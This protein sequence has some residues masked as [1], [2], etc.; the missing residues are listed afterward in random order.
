MGLLPFIDT[1]SDDLDQGVPD[2][3]AYKEAAMKFHRAVYMG[4][5]TTASH[6][7]SFGKFIDG[8]ASSMKKPPLVFP[9]FA[10]PTTRA[11]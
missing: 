6:F 11:G 5:P 7:S 10:R 9:E 3:L 1:T 2:P 4:A 8:T